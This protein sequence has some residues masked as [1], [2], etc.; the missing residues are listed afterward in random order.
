MC[1]NRILGYTVDG[2]WMDDGWWMVGWMIEFLRK[3]KLPRISWMPLDCLPKNLV[4]WSYPLSNKTEEIFL[5]SFPPQF[6][7]SV[8]NIHHIL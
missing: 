2:G 3:Q 6:C 8:S 4:I 7:M 1:A 5:A